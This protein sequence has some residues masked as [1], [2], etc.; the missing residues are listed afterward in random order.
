MKKT[1]RAASMKAKKQVASSDTNSG[2]SDV[3]LNMDRVKNILSEAQSLIEEVGDTEAD[4]Q[5]SAAVVEEGIVEE[6]VDAVNT[7]DESASDKPAKEE[8][9]PDDA[10]DEVISDQSSEEQG[11]SDIA[12]NE[13]EGD[14]AA[15]EEAED[16][17]D[18]AVTEEVDEEVAVE[19]IDAASAEEASDMGSDDFSDLPPVLIVAAESAPLAKT[20]G[21]AD[22]VGALPKYLRKIGVDARIIMPFHKQIKDIYASKATHLFS[23]FVGEQWTDRFVGIDKCEIDGTIYYFVDSE[24]YFGGPIY[25]GGNF[26]GEQYTFFMQV[27]CDVIP[28]LDFDPKIIHC[29]DWQTGLI[30]LKLKAKARK[31]NVEPR[32]MLMTIHNLAYQGTFGD[33][34]NVRIIGNDERAYAWDLGCWNMMK[35]GIDTADRV[36]TVSPTYAI[37][38]TTPEFGEGLQDDLRSVADQGRLSG[39][40]N[41]IDTDE[42]DPETDKYIAANYS[43]NKMGGKLRCKKAL[44]K[45]IGL[46]YEKDAPL[47]AMVGRLTWQKGI[48]IACD[49]MEDLVNQGVRFC[50][51]GSGDSGLEARLRDLE[52]RHK[53]RICSYIGYNNELS[54]RFY[55]ASDFF[56]MPSAFEPCGISQMIAMRYGSLPIVHETGG[57]KDTVIPYNA[58]TGEGCGFSFL[59]MDFWDAVEAC[60][61]ALSVWPNKDIMSRL[62]E[63]AMQM[64]FGFDRCAHSYAELY[65]SMR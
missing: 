41:G 33:D 10:V 9:D 35:A 64:D 22:V 12:A 44:M 21:L 7:T 54:H 17:L 30:P 5:T 46:E 38:I 61:R 50:V 16:V 52:A 45:E 26:E 29:N 48:G 37:Q 40:L 1:K 28:N 23:Y 63:N 6:A 49:V 62:I 65:R 2:E 19:N 60:K 53:G 25:T 31:F 42:W 39:I 8:T 58:Y 32:K 57:L 11:V 34:T 56:F 27:V 18:E 43:L 14:S 51:L 13:V 36:N 3:S 4:R 47:I 24:Y 55:A 15:A 59:R 20:G